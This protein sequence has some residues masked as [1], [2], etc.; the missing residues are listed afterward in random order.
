M[1]LC[2][3]ELVSEVKFRLLGSIQTKSIVKEAFMKRKEI[4]PSGKVVFLEKYIPW[5]KPIYE[6]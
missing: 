6:L 2:H 3:E 1:N 5:V 4:H